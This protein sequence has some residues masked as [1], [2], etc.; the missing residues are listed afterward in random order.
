[1]KG[2]LAYCETPLVS[3]DFK[4]NKLS[5]IVDAELTMCV[6]ENMVKILA[7]TTMSGAIATA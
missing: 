1:M 4:G 7:C 6:S 3:Q 2:V 5:S